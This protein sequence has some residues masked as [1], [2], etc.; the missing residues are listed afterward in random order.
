MK[1]KTIY[2]LDHDCNVVRVEVIE[3]KKK[4]KKNKKRSITM[5]IERLIENVHLERQPATK[6]KQIEK[7]FSKNYIAPGEL[8]LKFQQKVLWTFGCPYAPQCKDNL[9]RDKN[10]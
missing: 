5:N 9:K 3:K 7:I 1:T 10:L 8:P 6:A 2:H 4:K